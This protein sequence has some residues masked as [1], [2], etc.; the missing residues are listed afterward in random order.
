M[1]QSC[2][3]AV[4][5]Q[6]TLSVSFH[7]AQGRGSSGAVDIGEDLGGGNPHSCSWPENLV[8][9]KDLPRLWEEAAGAA[10]EAMSFGE[11]PRGSPKAG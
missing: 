8:G 5:T 11:A 10:R 9:C 3:R 6:A 2:P 1:L 4:F 7:G